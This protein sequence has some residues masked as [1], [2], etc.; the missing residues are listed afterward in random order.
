[1]KKTHLWT[2]GIILL[3]VILLLVFLTPRGNSFSVLENFEGEISVYRTPSCGCCGLYADYFKSKGNKRVEVVNIRDIS[4]VKKEYGVPSDLESCH[5]T[6]VGD[7]FVEG[8]I[9]LEAIEKLLSEEPDIAGI[10][11]P[12]MPSGSPGMPGRKYG[13]FVIYAIEH[14]GSYSEFMRI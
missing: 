1:V 9:P 5:M 8:H 4:S 12:D 6:V 11:M 13:D 2:I 7:Y 3:A 14:D 10:A